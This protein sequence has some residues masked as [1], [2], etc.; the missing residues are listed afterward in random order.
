MRLRE[1]VPTRSIAVVHGEDEHFGCGKFCSN[2]AG[3]LQAVRVGKRIVN[4][5]DI[6]LLFDGFEDRLPSIGSNGDYVEVW[7]RPPGLP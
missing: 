4:Y 6:G 3:D 2:L 5:C 7:M 1:G